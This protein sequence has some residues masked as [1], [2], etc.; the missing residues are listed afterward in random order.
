[1]KRRDFVTLLGGAAAWPLAAGAQQATQPAPVGLLAFGQAY[2][3][4]RSEYAS[5]EALT[6]VSVGSNE[7]WPCAAYGRPGN[8]GASF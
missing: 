1:M 3:R 7:N 8:I 2:E 5:Q 4:D 6:C